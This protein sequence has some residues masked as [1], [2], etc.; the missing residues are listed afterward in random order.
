MNE[1]TFKTI[2]RF[3][4]YKFGSDGSVWSAWGSYEG[5]PGKVIGPKWRRLSGTPNN[6]GY[7]VVHLSVVGSYRRRLV[8]VHSVILEAFVGP[9]PAP[10]LDCCH[11]DGN[12]MNCALANL[13]YDTKKNNVA[14]RRRHGTMIEGERSPNTKLSD[15]QV[16]KIRELA[17]A[18]TV[19][20][21]AFVYGVS[22]RS[23]NRIV[24]RSSWKHVA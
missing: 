21:I 13:R 6:T 18:H 20:S 8:S 23:I 7:P 16:V 2:E 22:R 4:G 17:P 3:A 24:D 5:H 9:K 14:D 12:R 19:S 11:N 10:E 15:H 1:V